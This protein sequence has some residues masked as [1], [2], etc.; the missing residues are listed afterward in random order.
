VIKKEG[1][2]DVTAPS[3]SLDMMQAISPVNLVYS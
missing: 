2:T 1:G 3:K